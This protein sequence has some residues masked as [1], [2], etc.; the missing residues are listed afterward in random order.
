MRVTPARAVIVAVLAC[1]GCAL[2]LRAAPDDSIPF[3]LGYREWSHVTG[4]LVGPQSP[5]FA[6]LGE[7]LK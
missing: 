3:P 6:S 7:F 4:A 1:L 5:A 2:G